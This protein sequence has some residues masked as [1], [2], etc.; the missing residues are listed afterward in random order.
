MS[1]LDSI[2]DPNTGK[3]KTPILIAG[4]G[5][6]GLFAL[7]M[8]SGKGGG[9]TT[10]TGLSTE[11]TPDLSALQDALKG[12]GGGGGGAS[13]SPSLD[14]PP[15]FTGPG[16]PDPIN[17]VA[18]VTPL[19][20]V[21]YIDDPTSSSGTN[22]T[23]TPSPT[24][25]PVVYLNPIIPDQGGGG[26]SSGG[27]GAGTGTIASPIAQNPVVYGGIAITPYVPTGNVG[28]TPMPVIRANPLPTGNVGVTPMPVI[29]A[30]PVPT[31][32]VGPTPMPIIRAVVPKPTGNVGPTPMPI[33]RATPIAI[34]TPVAAPTPLLVRNK[35]IAM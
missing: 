5:G 21:P 7:L 32:N 14:P 24:P 34:P 2:K 29:R 3:I 28:P 1:A 16:F 12:L 19:F 15:G 17:D 9:G 18:P 4:V 6:V 8:L 30:T 27:G 22:R 13:P 23:P 26:G 25:T 20:T 11:L 10:A 35:P 33:V 31:G